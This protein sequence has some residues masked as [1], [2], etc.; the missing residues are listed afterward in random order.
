[1]SSGSWLGTNLKS[2]L[3][4]ASA[5]GTVFIPSSVSEWMNNPT[6]TRVSS[7]G[8][9]WRQLRFPPCWMWWRQS[10]HFRSSNLVAP[11]FQRRAS[12]GAVHSTV[13]DHLEVDFRGHM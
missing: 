8:F 4:V 11:V 2:I 13:G 5:G 7:V 10:R 6:F 9:R 12:E 1:M 3:T